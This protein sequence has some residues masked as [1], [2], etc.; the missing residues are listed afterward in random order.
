MGGVREPVRK[1][2]QKIGVN[3]DGLGRKGNVEKVTD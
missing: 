3:K 2:E 1:A